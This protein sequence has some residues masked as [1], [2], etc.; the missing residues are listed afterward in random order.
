[1]ADSTMTD[2][3]YVFRYQQDGADDFTSDVEMSAL[4][5]FEVLAISALV[6][7]LS[8][9]SVT[10]HGSG[11]TAVRDGIRRSET[12]V[13]VD[14]DRESIERAPLQLVGAS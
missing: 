4:E 7:R 3:K 5:G 12:L 6:H 8:N 9:W 2:R 1:M 13:A 10:L 11:F 14:H